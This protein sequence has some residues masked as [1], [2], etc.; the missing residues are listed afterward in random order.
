M[1][2]YKNLIY[3]DDTFEVCTGFKYSDKKPIFHKNTK[4]IADSAFKDNYCLEVLDLSDTKVEKI[5]TRAFQNC[6]SL[7]HAI[8]P[9]TLTEIW[10]GTFNS[11]KK[12]YKIDLSNT[13]LK[14]IRR[15]AFICCAFDEIKLPNT[16]EVIGE[17]VFSSTPIKNLTLPSSLKYLDLTAFDNTE[18]KNLT[19]PANVELLASYLKPIMLKYVNLSMFNEISYTKLSPRDLTILQN[20][21]DNFHFNVRKI[22]LDFLIN[23]GKSFKQINDFYK[24]T[25]R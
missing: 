19:L 20:I 23:Q 13:N 17:Y 6:K 25:E 14:F 22:D 11:C 9:N 7:N 4:I 10:L 15:E 12:L 24:E 18:L 2:I 16:L 21:A 8:F 1:E 3:K 5:D